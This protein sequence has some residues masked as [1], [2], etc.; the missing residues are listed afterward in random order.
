MVRRRKL[1]AVCE[2][3][4]ARKLAS[5]YTHAIQQSAFCSRRCAAEYGLLAAG[6]E[7]DDGLN[8]C[9]LHGWFTNARLMDG[10]CP[11]CRPTKEPDE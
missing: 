11:E 10:G 7:G 6:A 3:R 5:R 2:S 4:P 1:C 9:E 8:W